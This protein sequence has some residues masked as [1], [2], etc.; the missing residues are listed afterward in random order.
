MTAQKYKIYGSAASFF[1]AARPGRTAYHGG[2]AMIAMVERLDDVVLQQDSWQCPA[3]TQTFPISTHDR[4]CDTPSKQSVCCLFSEP[5]AWSR[6]QERTNMSRMRHE[7]LDRMPVRCRPG[8]GDEKHVRWDQTEIREGNNRTRTR[9][10][11][12]AGMVFTAKKTPA[13]QRPAGVQPRL[14]NV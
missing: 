11:C 12:T 5:Y 2:R 13:G 8:A 4:S 7:D 9:D 6:Q 3:L 1:F 14:L 10:L